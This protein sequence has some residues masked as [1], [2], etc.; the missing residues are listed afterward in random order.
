MDEFEISGICDLERKNC[1]TGSTES[2]P[3]KLC[4]LSQKVQ[5]DFAVVR[6]VAMFP[7]VNALPGPEG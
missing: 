3:T 6:M 7:E 4:S 5:D 1:I 2:R